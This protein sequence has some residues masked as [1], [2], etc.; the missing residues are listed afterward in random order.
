METLLGLLI[1]I[2][3][4]VALIRFNKPSNQLA[5]ALEIKAVVWGAEIKTQAIKDLS[6]IKVDESTVEEANKVLTAI[7]KLKI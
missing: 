3:G 4:I 7:D 1:L 5:D 6:E 2:T